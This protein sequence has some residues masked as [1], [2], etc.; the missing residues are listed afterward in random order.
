MSWLTNSSTQPIR[1]CIVK[2]NE[3]QDLARTTRL[4][5]ADAIYAIINLP[6]EVGELCSK[7]AKRRRDMSDK[8]LDEAYMLGLKKEV[9]DILWQLA[10]ICDD[11]DFTLEE[12]A[13]INLGK[14]KAREKAGQ[15][16]GSGDDR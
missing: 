11:H 12:C 9:G 6:G 15:L 10:A 1:D 7:I 4:P 3:F 5:T 8:P 14:L 13:E 2:F 16:Q